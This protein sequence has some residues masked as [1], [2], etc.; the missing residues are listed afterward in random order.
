MDGRTM[1][2]SSPVSGDGLAKYLD[3]VEPLLGEERPGDTFNDHAARLDLT[4]VGI[5]VGL[6]PP[7]EVEVLI[8]R[9]VHLLAG[10]ENA[11]SP[12]VVQHRIRR[13]GGGFGVVE[14]NVARD[15]DV[16]LRLEQVDHDHGYP[17][18]VGTL[19]GGLYGLS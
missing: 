19:D 6:L 2:Y 1:V 11:G 9:H 17:G 14:A 18:L 8:L 16:V 4:R 10:A 7:L 5:L 13:N 15:L 3:A 12:V